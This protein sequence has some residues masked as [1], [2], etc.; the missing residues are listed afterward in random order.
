MNTEDWDY[1]GE[2][3]VHIALCNN[4]C[5][6]EYFGFVL[7]VPKRTGCSAYRSQFSSTVMEDIIGK[8]YVS[9]K[10]L[11]IELS[12]QFIGALLLRIQ[13][14]R[15]K[16]RVAK[17]GLT[18]HNGILVRNFGVIYRTVNAPLHLMKDTIT[19]ELKVKGGDC[20]SSPFI[21][22]DRTVKL[23]HSRFRLMQLYKTTNLVLGNAEPFAPVDWGIICS[24]SN[25]E[26]GELCSR[27]NGRVRKSLTI[28]LKN[29]QNNFRICLNGE[30]IYGWDLNNFESLR[31]HLSKSVFGNFNCSGGCDDRVLSLVAAVLCEEEVLQRLQF[32]QRLDLLDV[33]GAALAFTRLCELLG[34]P[35]PVLSESD[36]S[37]ES[38]SL[39]IVYEFLAEH[40]TTPIYPEILKTIF[41]A[42]CNN[43]CISIG[44]QDGDGSGGCG[45]V[46][47]VRRLALLRVDACMSAEKRDRHRRAA[48]DMLNACSAEQCALLLQLWMV[49][50][51]AKDASVIVTMQACAPVDHPPIFETKSMCYS[52]RDRDSGDSGA[53][54]VRVIK[55]SDTVCG[56]VSESTLQRDTTADASAVFRCVYTVGVI[57]LGLKSLDKAWKK[58]LDEGYVCFSAARTAAALKLNIVK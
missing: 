19:I 25:Y 36:A 9:D 51:V 11:N 49:S 21:P 48:V 26:P 45:S 2:G 33:E 13:L 46:E 41:S 50:L 5:N 20:A 58:E 4:K 55:Q 15:P 17:G 12:D 35:P 40:M 57:D 34:V 8:E 24:P 38:Q 14:L 23:R 43:S 39:S 3:K 28:L 32:A 31:E 30:H 22:E 27:E 37:S 52:C 7:L 1:I 47:L 10:F 53:V 44:R 54:Q 56:I 18:S 29:P 16:K 42:N 6:S